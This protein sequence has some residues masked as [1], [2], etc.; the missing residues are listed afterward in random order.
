MG[1]I[2]G[3]ININRKT[4]YKIIKQFNIVYIYTGKGIN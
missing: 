2:K 4:V 3:V 1:F